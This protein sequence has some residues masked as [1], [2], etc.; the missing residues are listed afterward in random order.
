MA[1]LTVSST[2]NS[3][4]PQNLPKFNTDHMLLLGA[5]LIHLNYTD[6]TT[7]LL[8]SFNGCHVCGGK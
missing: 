3:R 2:E 4:K 8:L 6:K 7:F 5:P 1:S